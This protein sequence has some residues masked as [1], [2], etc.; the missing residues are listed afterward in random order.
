MLFLD[1]ERH[2]SLSDDILKCISL[3][4]SLAYLGGRASKVE[5]TYIGYSCL[6]LFRHCYTVDTKYYCVIIVPN[7][8]PLDDSSLDCD[9]V[10]LTAPI[11]SSSSNKEKHSVA[12]FSSESLD[13]TRHM[14][15]IIVCIIASLFGEGEVPKIEP[16][17]GS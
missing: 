6:S 10:M 13:H 17:D 3:W 16:P 12:K 4:F 7:I 5:T 15:G 11:S 14:Q 9:M 8:E 2:F 1:N